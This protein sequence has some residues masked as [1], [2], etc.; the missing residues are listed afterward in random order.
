MEIIVD[1]DKKL[2]EV[3]LSH[4]ESETPETEAALKLI[5]DE[6]SKMKFKTVVFRSGGGNLSDYVEV[7]IRNNRAK[8]AKNDLAQKSY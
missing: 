6:Y 3:W 4:I 2:V 1:K 5:Y 7:L 8:I